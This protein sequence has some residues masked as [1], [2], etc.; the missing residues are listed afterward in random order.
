MKYLVW[1]VSA[2]NIYFGF[3]CVLNAIHVLH[4]SKYSQ[5]TTGIFA[6]LFL[7]LGATGFY[8]TLAL[9]DACL[10]MLVGVGPWLLALVVLFLAMITGKQQ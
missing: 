2:L 3:R 7:G 6:I 4:T 10:G 8:V 5:T 9:H 1:I